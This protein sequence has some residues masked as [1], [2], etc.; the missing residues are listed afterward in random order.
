MFKLGLYWFNWISWVIL[1][2]IYILLGPLC[3]ISSDLFDW[4]IGWVSED[5]TVTLIIILLGEWI[6]SATLIFQLMMDRTGKNIFFY[7][8]IFFLVCSNFVFIGITYSLIQRDNIIEQFMAK[9]CTT[10]LLVL[11][12]EKMKVQFN[13]ELKENCGI[14]Y[15]KI[16]N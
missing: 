14:C 2:P 15:E 9:I 8:F 3:M 4:F 10:L 13:H 5:Q 16:N 1:I 12:A 7:E 6:I 11:L